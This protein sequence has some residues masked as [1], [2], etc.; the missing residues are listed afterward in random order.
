MSEELLESV[1]APEVVEAVNESVE[2][3]YIVDYD[4]SMRRQAV[5]AYKPVEER[6]DLLEKLNDEDTLKQL[7]RENEVKKQKKKN[8]FSFKRTK[9]D[10]AALD[11]KKKNVSKIKIP[12]SVQESIPY[13]NMYLNGIVEIE[14]GLFSKIYYMGDVNFKIALSNKQESI[15]AAYGDLLNQFDSTCGIAVTIYNR[16]IDED[17]FSKEVLLKMESDGLNE[18][19]KE[20]NDM[21]LNKVLEGNNNLKHEKYLTV[22]IESD[23]IE[24]A[25]K[26]FSRID[27][28]IYSSIRKITKKETKPL[29]PKE[30]LNILYSVYNLDSEV[31][32]ESQNL[33][34]RRNGKVVK[35]FD[36]ADINAAGL[37]TKDIIAPSSFD[38]KSNHFK[39]GQ[40][41]GRSF[42]LQS[43]PNYVKTDFIPDMADTPCNML[44]TVHYR[45]VRQDQ[46]INLI[47]TQTTNIGSSVVV[48]QKNASKGGYSSDLISPDLQ[49]AQEEAKKLMED[50]TTRNQRLFFVTIVFTIFAKDKDELDKNSKILKTTA[51][52]HLFTLKPLT[53]QQELGL[54]SSLPLGKNMLKI[55]RL[56]TTES[57]S[58]FIPFS[59]QEWLE[60][61]GFYY[62]VNAI[63]R[64]MVIYNRKDSNNY[65]GVI[66]GRPGAGKSFSAKRSIVQALLNTQDDVYVIDPE[67]EYKYVSE[68]LTKT[69]G[70]G[71][72]IPTQ[73]I[74]LKV[75]GNVYINPFDLD[76]DS[77]DDECPD[78]LRAKADFIV[79]LCNVIIGGT[80]G[81]NKG[82]ES[83]LDRCILEVYRDYMDTMRKRMAINPNDSIDRSICPTFEDLY[84]MLL[85]QVEPEAEQLALDLERYIKGSLDIFAHRTNVET[86]GRF[87]VYDIKNVAGMMEF[88]L[89]VCL[90]SMWTAMMA[91]RRAGRFTWLWIDEFHI[92]AQRKTSADYAMTIFKRARKHSGIPTALTQNIGDMLDCK[93]MRSIL[94]NSNFIMMLDQAPQEREELASMFHLS[95]EEKAYITDAEPG[96]GLIYNSKAIIPFVD[97]FPEDTKLYVAMSTKPSDDA[98][99]KK[100]E[101][102]EVIDDDNWFDDAIDY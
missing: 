97:E 14:E 13:R 41:Y 17:R 93:Q 56:N 53:F 46:A 16:S 10:S 57:S 101:E 81:L 15:F 6:R 91:N 83:V 38:F 63:S 76:L 42:Y 60:K 84:D 85:T 27:G 43:F 70:T 59:V 86:K 79:S 82:Q 80:Y 62:G 29:S 75:G 19:R 71:S 90:D 25:I 49:K 23:N 2:R 20:Y 5:S 26:E 95:E 40:V 65:N 50:I 1:K 21:L 33:S 92:L 98:G 66:F 52:R 28:E 36:L 51:Q 58:V 102:N 39:M 47:K 69:D 96:H 35:S 48:A 24:T 9:N 73:V 32:L 4:R 94:N 72:G 7:S 68:M 67:N 61:D 100:Q 22:T 31:P 87:I 77:A 64:N 99:F 34:N 8:I 11:E 89:Q 44:I 45:S 55:A 12:R 54:N 37:S 88:A 3:N 74:S 30:I 78:P 18:Y